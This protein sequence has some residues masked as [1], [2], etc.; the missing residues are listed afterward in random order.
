MAKTNQKQEPVTAR[1]P[2]RSRFSIPRKEAPQIDGSYLDHLFADFQQQSTEV[3]DSP[4]NFHTH[5]LTSVN[6]PISVPGVPSSNPAISQL[7]I[8]DGLSVPLPHIHPTIPI[9]PDPN[10]KNRA[11]SE[12]NQK[13]QKKITSAKKKI[14][15]LIS[16]N[17]QFIR[18]TKQFRLA[19]GEISTLQ[20]MLD[21][22]REQGTDTCYIKIPQISL[23]TQ[24]SHRQTQRILFRLQEAG[25]VERLS[26]YSNADKLGILFRLTLP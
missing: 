24:L 22:C 4:T 16:E 9:K 18:L 1:K 23:A 10:E 3:S 20:L 25:F 12:K 2:G 19:K 15:P 21:M 26:G 14:S 13:N 11:E 6:S 17:E 7:L 8:D 5:P